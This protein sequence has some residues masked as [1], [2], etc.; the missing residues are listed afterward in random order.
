METPSESFDG[1]CQQRKE[2]QTIVIVPEDVHPF[3]A[4]GCDVPKGTFEFKSQRS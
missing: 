4:S 3:I 2:Q 1:R